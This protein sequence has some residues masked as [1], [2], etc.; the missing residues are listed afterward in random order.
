MG[1]AT[2]QERW[3]LEMGSQKRFLDVAHYRDGTRIFL[4]RVPCPNGIYA[5]QNNAG[6]KLT[7]LGNPA[8]AWRVN[9]DDVPSERLA[10][11]RNKQEAKEGK[12]REDW[13]LWHQR[14]EN[15]DFEKVV[16]IGVGV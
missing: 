8:A 2:K 12:N 5:T 16:T 14:F 3:V 11:K 15:G 4:L 13:E 7:F 1:R 10:S 9:R 6:S